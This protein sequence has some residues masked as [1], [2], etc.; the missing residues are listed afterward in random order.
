MTNGG[1]TLI[2][3]WSRVSSP[4]RTQAA[5]TPIAVAWRTIVLLLFILLLQACTTPTGRL[6]A[7]ATGNDLERSRARAD[8]FNMLV[9]SNVDMPRSAVRSVAG[10]SRVLHVYLEGDGSPWRHRTII[11]PDPTPRNPLMLRL[12]SYD[13]AASIYVGR[14]CYNGFS[15]DSGC[16][17]QLWT[18]ARYSPTVVNSMASVI[19][20]RARLLEAS[21]LWLMGH[22]GGGALAMLLAHELPD[23][24]R[25]VTIAGNLD[26]DAWTQFHQ[27]SPL[28]TS[29]NPARQPLL[30]PEI[31]QWHFIGGV[32]KVIPPQL[33]KPVILRQPSAR[34]FEFAGFG[35]GCCWERIWPDVLDALQQDNPDGIP[36][37]QFKFPESGISN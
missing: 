11:M 22:S 6:T 8:G 12:M 19:R 31:S 20:S 37:T 2:L 4:G 7:F 5:S 27:Y 35:H 3:F 28:Y 17:N 1:S 13:T 30:R 36:G 29:L 26:T 16:G 21:E 34:G 9:F 18:S 23:V 32:D 14:P 25:V 15:N 10:E 33:I 24:T